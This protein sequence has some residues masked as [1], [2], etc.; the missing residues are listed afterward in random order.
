MPRAPPPSPVALAPEAPRAAPAAPVAVAPEPP[1]AVSP[2]PVPVPAPSREAAIAP[3]HRPASPQNLQPVPGDARRPRTASRPRDAA[4]PGALAG[5]GGAGGDSPASASPGLLDLLSRK[6]DAPT[7]P[8]EPEDRGGTA[9]PGVQDVETMVQRNRSGFLACTQGAGA[10]AGLAGRSVMLSVTVNL[11][12][13]VTSPR[14]DNPLLDASAAGTC[15]KSAAR[16]FVLAPFSGEPVRV[17]VP[18]TLSP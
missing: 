17:R 5:R 3:G 6:E 12:G 10:P 16:N 9:V 13:I 8:A 7:A 2:V 1:V 4:A 14:L 11:S 18:L 15:L